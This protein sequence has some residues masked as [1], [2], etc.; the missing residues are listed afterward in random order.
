MYYSFLTFIF[1]GAQKKILLLGCYI[2]E[3]Y[4][5]CDGTDCTGLGLALVLGLG[6]GLGL[7]SRFR[8]VSFSKM[9]HSLTLITKR[10]MQLFVFVARLSGA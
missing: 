5:Q 10:N 2:S 6:L 9:I 1:V 3:K 8:S 4:T 7:G